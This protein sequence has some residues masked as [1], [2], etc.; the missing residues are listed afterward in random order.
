MN[1]AEDYS[2]KFQ[3]VSAEKIVKLLNEY[4]VKENSA[5]KSKDNKESIL[6][7]NLI[8]DFKIGIHFRQVISHKKFI[9]RVWEKLR[10]HFPNVTH[11]QILQHDASKI[12]SLTEILGY[13]GTHLFSLF[14]VRNFHII[15]LLK[16]QVG[17]ESRKPTLGRRKSSSF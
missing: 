11:D 3:N 7:K 5:V 17:M 10:Q 8:D 1:K 4:F 13:T 9:N 15:I 2:H 16:R 12:A 6:C 14:V